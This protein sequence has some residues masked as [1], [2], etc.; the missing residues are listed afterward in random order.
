[1][2]TF[3]ITFERAGASD[4]NNY[5][6]TYSILAQNSQETT[7]WDTIA[8]HVV[9]NRTDN[10][11]Q[12]YVFDEKMYDTIKIVMHSCKTGASLTNNGW[13]AI[14]E[15]AVL[16]LVEEGSNSFE[17]VEGNYVNLGKK[18]LDISEW[19]AALEVTEEGLE[20]LKLTLPDN[21]WLQLEYMMEYQGPT[22]AVVTSTNNVRWNGMPK[23]SGSDYENDS[24]QYDVMG[25]IIPNA[26][27]NIEVIKVDENNL[28]K[29]LKGAEFDVIKCQVEADGSITELTEQSKH[30]I[31]NEDGFATT[32]IV[33]DGLD[34]NTVYCL[35]ET[36]AP[37]GYMLNSE[38]M[39]FAVAKQINI[40]GT[41]AYPQFPDNVYV[42][43]Q[44]ATYTYTC[45]NGK[46]KI[47]LDKKFLASEGAET[48]LQDGT[49]QFGL[50]D[51]EAPQ[52]NPLQKITMTI[53]NENVSYA[54]NGDETS[55]PYF[56][57]IEVNTGKKYYIY[58]L[59]EQG[60]PVQD[61]SHVI[62]DEANYVVHYPDNN[63][64][65][66]DGTSIPVKEVHNYL[67]Y[68]LPES[69][70]MGTHLHMLLGFAAILLSLVLYLKR[71]LIKKGEL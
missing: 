22:G 64:I 58:E 11:E 26:Y 33:G 40:D 36:K 39:Y 14:A 34:F 13:P 48:Q 31:T 47:E 24:F 46:G 71:Q 17:N 65:M 37:E 53:K 19:N 61:G 29:Y 43:T 4:S 57:D 66:V 44:T 68:R 38:P 45:L 41:M 27:A 21:K 12:N 23:E 55:L 67:T 10:Y 3:T 35:R 5:H 28:R 7:D 15:F 20:V 8:D 52:G 42:H 25:T 60:N 70:G 59:D 32:Y 62:I 18:E 9:A 2:D 63:P 50:Y 51:E 6:F 69:G 54:L 30:I 1:M 16:G 56:V 49:Y